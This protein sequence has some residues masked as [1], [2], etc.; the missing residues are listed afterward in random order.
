MPSDPLSHFILD[1]VDELDLRQA[2]V[3]TR[4]TGSE[5]YPPSMLLSLLLYSYATGVFSSRRTD[6]SGV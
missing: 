5:Q 4:G 1:A 6:Q 2:R 3:N